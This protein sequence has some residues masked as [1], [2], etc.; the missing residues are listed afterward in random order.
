M[1]IRSGYVSNSSSSSFIMLSNKKF[2]S[3][4]DIYEF[5]FKTK[6]EDD[7]K[8]FIHTE[9]IEEVLPADEAAKYLWQQISGNFKEKQPYL[10]LAADYGRP[11][12][13]RLKH[14]LGGQLYQ[15]SLAR[16]GFWTNGNLISF[17]DAN[18]L[19]TMANLN[20]K[21]S[22]EYYKEYRRTADYLV[23]E[24]RKA[25]NTKADKSDSYE[26]ESMLMKRHN[27]KKLNDLKKME[28]ET[29][30][31]LDNKMDQVVNKI[32]QNIKN[33]KK[34]IYTFEI[35]DNHGPVPSPWGGIM[36]HGNLLNKLSAK[37]Y[38]KISNH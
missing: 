18:E 38:N 27:N 24:Y 28:N 36:E 1:K 10:S 8:R 35:G 37:E 29:R 21:Y 23:K 25:N 9:Y 5:L 15:H 22:D 31:K 2:K 14:V 30:E 11:I 33:M 13:E 32:I 34:Y 20:N 16:D 19:D 12:E 3:W 4:Q 6:P 7:M 26:I 17:E